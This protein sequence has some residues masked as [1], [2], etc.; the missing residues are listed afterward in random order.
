MAEN[1]AGSGPY[2]LGAWDRN[3]Q[4][5]LERNPDYWGGWGDKYLDTIIVRPVG[6]STTMR[7]MIEKG[8]AGCGHRHDHR[9]RWTRWPR[10]PA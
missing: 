1:D 10:P 7:L 5:I 6:E 3:Q 8:D 2:K 4:I 9:G